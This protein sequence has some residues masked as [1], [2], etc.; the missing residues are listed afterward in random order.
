MKHQINANLEN[1]DEGWFVIS[2][3]SCDW[4]SQGDLALPDPE[5]AADLYAEHCVLMALLEKT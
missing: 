5:T 1:D 3:G 2:C 4:G